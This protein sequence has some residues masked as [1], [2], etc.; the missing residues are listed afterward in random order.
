MP[1]LQMLKS[2]WREEQAPLVE[3]KGW[4]RDDGDAAER[5]HDRGDQ[6]T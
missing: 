4:S 1:E 3:Q 5:R 2:G 6:A